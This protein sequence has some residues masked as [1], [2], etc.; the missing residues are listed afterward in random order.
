MNTLHVI[1]T[2]FGRAIHLRRIID[3]FVVQTCQRWV[4]H[5]VHDGPPSKEILAVM[6]VYNDSRI[7]FES[8][9][10]VNGLWGHPNRQMML[11]KMPLNHRDYVLIT[12]DDNDYVPVF[13][14]MMLKKANKV[15]G[16]VY[17]D[18]VHSYLKYDI[19]RSQVK[20]N[21][22]DM[23]SFIVRIDVAKKVGFNDMHFSADGT[24][25]VKCASHA[26]RLK[27]PVQHIGLP[28]AIHN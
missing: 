1:I 5:I 16:M 17:C 22:I 6:S 26:G 12:N 25:A 2:V 15:A 20:E 28:L 14:E 9:P 7:Q 19:L 23:G 21:L 13:V 24:F 18:T 4:L 11:R 8:T 27:L 10:R 3:C